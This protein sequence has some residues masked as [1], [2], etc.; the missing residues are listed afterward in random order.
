M[1]WCFDIVPENI[2]DNKVSKWKLSFIVCGL[3]S[4]KLK[5]ANFSKS[6]LA[7]NWQSCA[8]GFQ[9]FC[10]L[11]DRLKTPST[12]IRNFLSSNSVVFGLF[13]VQISM[14]IFCLLCGIVVTRKKYVRLSLNF[15]FIQT[16]C[17]VTLMPHFFIGVASNKDYSLGKW[18]L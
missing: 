7:E 4:F 3:W 11:I 13:H 15:S 17:L 14:I 8:C 2:I 18:I 10:Y 16:F 5:K 6:A 12:E 1:R 9:K